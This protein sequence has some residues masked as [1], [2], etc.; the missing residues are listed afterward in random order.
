[1]RLLLDTHAFLWWLAGDRKLPARVRRRIAAPHAA[2][3]V[4]AASAWEIATKWRLGKL[5]EA[6]LVARDVAGAVG[7]Q[8]FALLPISVAH[9]EHAGRLAITHRD[10]FDR[11]LIAQ[12]RLEGIPV[13]SSDE[14]F[15]AFG[16][17]RLW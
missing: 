15:D 10:P 4:S 12:A 3:F 9:A 2:V 7:A 6:D 17:E 16:I 11:L 8:G 5:N 13:A 1:M 14:I